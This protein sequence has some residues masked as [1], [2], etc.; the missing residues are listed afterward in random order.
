MYP[1]IDD[2]TRRYMKVIKYSKKDIAKYFDLEERYL[3][4]RITNGAQRPTPEDNE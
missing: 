1:F 2:E 3:A 4:T